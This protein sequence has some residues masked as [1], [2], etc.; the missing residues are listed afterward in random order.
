MPRFERNKSIDNSN[1]EDKKLD[2]KIQ[3]MD[4]S[5]IIKKISFHEDKTSKNYEE[6]FFSFINQ[7]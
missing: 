5:V 3:I 2:P 6:E 4:D 7:D 1:D